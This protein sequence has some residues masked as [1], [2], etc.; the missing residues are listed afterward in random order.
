EYLNLDPERIVE[1]IGSHAA[2]IDCFGILNDAE[3][4][5]YFELGCEVKGLG[6]GHVKRIKDDVRKNG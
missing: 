1:M 2:I 5:R 3:I 6:R 4:K